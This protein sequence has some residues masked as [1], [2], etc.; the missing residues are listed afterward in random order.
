MQRILKALVIILLLTPMMVLAGGKKQEKEKKP[1]AF[2]KVDSVSAADNTVTITDVDGSNKTYTVNAHTK[3]VID[4]KPGKLSDISSGLKA[5]VTASGKT[6]SRIEVSEP[7]AEKP[8]KKK[9]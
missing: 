5:D 6:I 3:I 8:E 7:P 4:G 9:K 1:R 2:Q